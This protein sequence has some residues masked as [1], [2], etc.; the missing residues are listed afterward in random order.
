MENLVELS[1]IQHSM[2]H[3]AEWKRKGNWQDKIA[4][5]A[6]SGHMS[7]EEAIKEARLRGAKNQPGGWKISPEASANLSRLRKG[8]KLSEEH[9]AKLRKPHKNKRKPLSEEHREARS[10]MMKEKW[11]NVSDEDKRAHMEKMWKNNPKFR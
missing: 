5:K 2:W 7:K 3:F 10:E 1:L 6:L 11:K 9:K 8:K 4:W